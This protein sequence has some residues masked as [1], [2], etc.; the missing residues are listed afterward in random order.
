MAE[1]SLALETEPIRFESCLRHSTHGTW[2]KSL[3]LLSEEQI[4]YLL[5]C[6]LYVP[7]L[8]LPLCKLHF[9]L[10]KNG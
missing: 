7:G 6:Y 4:L 10:L 9:F 5:V 3:I 2:I 1:K 8:W